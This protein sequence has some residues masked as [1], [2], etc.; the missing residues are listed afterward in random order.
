MVAKITYVTKKKYRNAVVDVGAGIRKTLLHREIKI[1][2]Q[3]CRTDDYVTATR[4]F[5]CS[6][7]NHRAMDCTGEVI[8]PLCAGSQSIK[9][10]KL[11]QRLI[12]S[13]TM[14]ITRIR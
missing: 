3:I 10:C 2:W 12:V 1:G 6:N 13:A 14:D 9:E 7:L 5:K 8:C 4:C 11:T